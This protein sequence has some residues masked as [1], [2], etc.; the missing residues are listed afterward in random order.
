MTRE[1]ETQR[2]QVTR[3]VETD[4]VRARFKERDSDREVETQREIKV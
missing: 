1:L 3:E 2:D 4:R